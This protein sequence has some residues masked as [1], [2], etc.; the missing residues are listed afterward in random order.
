MAEVLMSHTLLNTAEEAHTRG[1]KQDHRARADGLLDSP[2]PSRG[3]RAEDP[4]VHKAGGIKGPRLGDGERK[5][6]VQGEPLLPMQVF[7]VPA[8]TAPRATSAPG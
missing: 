3:Q 5:R 8:T 2:I 6:D 1:Y 7:V 4:G